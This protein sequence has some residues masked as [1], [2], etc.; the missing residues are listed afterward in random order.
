MRLTDLVKDVDDYTAESLE[1]Y[2]V[3]YVSEAKIVRDAVY[4]FHRFHPHEVAII[5]SPILQRLRG[6]H[7]TAL[8][9]LVYPSANH[10]RFEHSLGVATKAERMARALR[11]APSST[12]VPEH[13]LL[14]LRLA[15]L[16]HDVG[17]GLFSHLTESILAERHRS[18]LEEIRQADEFAEKTSL[19]EALS[20]IVVR[21]GAFRRLLGEVQDRYPEFEGLNR[22][23]TDGIAELILGSATD[24]NEQYLADIISGPFDADKLD[25]L[26]HDS[27]FPG[28]RA[29]VDWE[30]I[31]HAL[32]V[33]EKEGTRFLAVWSGAVPQLEHILFSKMLMHSAVYH[34]HKIRSLEQLVRVV[35]ELAF[36]R[37]DD[38]QEPLFALDRVSDIWRLSEAE[39]FAF[40]Q[41]E[42]VV[43]EYVAMIRDRQLMQ[44]ALSLN[45]T[46][47]EKG[48]N[49]EG[50]R[51]F[52]N[53]F[54][55][56]NAPEIARYLEAAVYQSLSPEIRGTIDERLLRFDF[57]NSPSLS[58][59]AEQCNV[60]VRPGEARTLK[61][62]F[63]IEDWTASY[64][65]NKLTAHLFLAGDRSSRAAVA[66]AGDSVLNTV[67]GLELDQGARVG[68]K[69]NMEE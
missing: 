27:H 63:P 6:V 58:D 5:D 52:Q 65:D 64:S 60:L 31:V 8:A 13:R 47:I 48:P 40:G 62:F 3:S 1:E 10:T 68:L 16:L 25:Y 51:R 19:G 38:L 7:Q 29:E 50:L 55:D 32:D 20:A 26:G 9:H 59:D 4:G 2:K 34:H 49:M 43:S 45:I 37:R 53:L 33:W 30:R 67:F 17:H 24:P 15:G 22:V 12:D 36:A 61:P 21:S 57:P 46:T 41:R 66:D 14:E 42:P 11:T 56:P 35:F 18:V 28:L 54:A 23:S 69:E 44:R 39:F